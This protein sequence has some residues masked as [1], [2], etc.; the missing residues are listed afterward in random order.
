MIK[1]FRAQQDDNDA[2]LWYFKM[3]GLATDG[4]IRYVDLSRN[5]VPEAWLAT[6]Q[7]EAQLLI[8]TGQYN[9]DL[10][11]RILGDDAKSEGKQ[12]LASNPIARG[13]ITQDLD[14]VTAWIDTATVPQ[15]RELLKVLSIVARELVKR[16]Y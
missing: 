13:L 3:V 7:A 14:V 1:I 11:R 6:N 8:N 12:W 2:T 15:L 16:E 5:A 9:E 10:E 4:K